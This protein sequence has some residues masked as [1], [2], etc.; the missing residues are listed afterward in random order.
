MISAPAVEE[1]EK[2]Y[3]DLCPK[4]SRREAVRSLAKAVSTR[5][6]YGGGRTYVVQKGDTLYDIARYELGK[7]S[8]WAEIHA[9]NA[10]LLGKD[11]DYLV[12]GT[13]LV[14]PQDG[15]PADAMTRRPAAR[16]GLPTLVRHPP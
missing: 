5:L 6:P 7:A 8:R 10:D 4:P 11:Y 16:I 1:L 14:L 12:P 9:L 2:N 13:Q 15:A 3:P